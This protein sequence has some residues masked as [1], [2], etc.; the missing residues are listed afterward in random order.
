MTTD[1]KPVPTDWGPFAAF[2]FAGAV[3]LVGVGF[4][5]MYHYESG[6]SSSTRIVEGDAYN[7]IIIAT[8]GVGWIVAAIVL[9]LLGVG[10]QLAALRK[11]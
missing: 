8:R 6:Y 10:A 9:A 2:C 1:P 4:Y 3:I 5:T 7:Y 11:P